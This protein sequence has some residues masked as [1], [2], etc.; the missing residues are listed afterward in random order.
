MKYSHELGVGKVSE[1][2]LW[3]KDFC[4]I[5]AAMLFVSLVFY[6]LMTAMTTY[7]IE[8]FNA[9]Q[10]QAG[11]AS[12]I[13]VIGGLAA[14]LLAGRYMEVIGCKKMLYGSLC[15]FLIATL[16]YFPANTLV[17]LLVVR[18]IHGAAFGF[19]TTAMPTAIIDI[20]STERRGE[21]ISYFSLSMTM[22]S[23]IGPFLGIFIMKY[24]DFN[25]MFAVCT[26]FSV[27]S[28]II[29][30]YAQI[31]EIRVR[32]KQLDAIKEFTGQDFFEKSAIPI[33]IVMLITGI[34]F[35]GI[36]T[37]L[38]SYAIHI[39]LS[40]AASFFFIVYATFILISRPFTGRLLDVKGDNIVMYPALLIFTS[41]LV[42]LSRAESGFVL[43]LAGALVGLGFGTIMSCAQVIA[44]KKVPQHRIG[45]ATATF[46]FC[47]DVGVGIGPFLI[48]SII[49]IVGFRGMYVTMAVAVFLSIFLYYFLHGK[50]A[51]AIN[52]PAY[53]SDGIG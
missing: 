10:S 19:A 53:I 24:A 22:A 28:I 4:L 35:S 39:N 36:L 31:P 47:L 41:S 44:T 51:A 12:G 18:F 37:F 50:K 21:G 23:A 13:F 30:L 15:F 27:V 43:L 26:G 34:A 38:N 20:V 1:S 3:T 29:I 6:L 14:R 32:N 25:M 16:L 8:Q 5:F 42:L 46:L 52:Q 17:L 11:L 40:T 7:A 48:G 9:S 33:S 2:K 45:L 49:P